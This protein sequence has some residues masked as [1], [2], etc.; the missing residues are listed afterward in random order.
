[1]RYDVRTVSMMEG[2]PVNN[3]GLVPGTWDRHAL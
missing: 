1:M 3:G 2:G